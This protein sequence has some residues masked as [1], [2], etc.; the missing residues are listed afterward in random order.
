MDEGMGIKAHFIRYDFINS[1]IA[2]NWP[3]FSK[4]SNHFTVNNLKISH[5]KLKEYFVR[6]LYLY[7][8]YISNAYYGSFLHGFD[9]PY[10]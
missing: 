7:T 4:H 10:L 2:V 1:G 6:I 3:S 5:D 8:K 9:I